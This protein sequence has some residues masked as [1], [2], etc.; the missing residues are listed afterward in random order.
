MIAK[1]HAVLSA[2]SS[3]RW[4][5]CP[6]SVRLEEN[7]PNETS[8]FAEEGTFMHEL[9]EYKVRHDYLHENIARPAS[10]QWDSPEVEAVTDAY[11]NFATEAISELNDPM[12][13]IEQKLDYS[14]IAPYGFGTGDLILIDDTTLHVIDF[15]GG[16]GVFVNAQQNSQMM[17]YALG[18]LAGY[19]YLFDIENVKM[20][21]VQPRLS[22][23][24][25]YEC[26][27]AELEA[28]GESIKPVARLAYEG[29]G[30]QRIGDWCRF[31]R[32]RPRCQAC[33][34]EAL[35]LCRA[36]FTDLETFKSP[37]LVP[38]SELVEVFPLLNNMRSWI[39][40]V[41]SYVTSE[42][43][44]HRVTVKGY[45]VAEGV[46]RRTFTDINAVV[47]KA[48]E[49]GY[50]ATD[51]FKQTPITLTEFEK[52]MGKEKFKELLG[53]YVVKP[54]GKPILVKE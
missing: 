48:V 42:A 18:A 51:V 28:W 16:G 12:I 23:I 26:S 38:I 52:L 39:D 21:I 54:K 3:K 41:I 47:K 6:P 19:G 40:A 30:E 5:N 8:P 49:N 46:S 24:S 9:C 17:L 25:T 33:K 44:E 4:L 35:S 14:H 36:E 7:F 31:C 10:E 27:R 22:N 53:E 2:S 15:K 32:A 50:A 45:K 37:E 43:V 13:L 11:Y 34:D 1:K 20:S 29:R